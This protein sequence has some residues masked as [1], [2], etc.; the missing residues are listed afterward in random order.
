MPPTSPRAPRIQSQRT[1][2][3]HRAGQGHRAEGL[4]GAGHPLV[5]VLYACEATIDAIVAV[6]AIQLGALALWW[7]QASS[8]YA[9]AIGAG[10]VQ[11]ALHLRWATLRAERR[12]L[13]LELL[14]AGRGRLPL[15]AVARER[16]RLADPRLQS[17][18]AASFDHLAA[19][20][21]LPHRRRERQLS[22]CSRRVLA[23]VEPQLRDIAARLRAGDVDVRGVALLERLATCGTS[24]LYG[25]E[26]SSLRDEL[27]R[28]RYLLA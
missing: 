17:R 4:L 10:I 21:V 26:A 23:A 3:W 16:R 22:M 11:L 19:L 5:A 12:D 7:L 2:A 18:L 1:A 15:T 25:E 6:A 20:A 13:C 9:L 28:G 8:A 24:P 27:A 14:I